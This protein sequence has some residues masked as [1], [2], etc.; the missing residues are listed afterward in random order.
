[1]AKQPIYP[2]VVKSGRSNGKSEPQII[3]KSYGI[4][5]GFLRGQQIFKLSELEP[6]LRSYFN[7]GAKTIVITYDALRVEWVLEPE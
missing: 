5:D 3:R 7:I 6:T 4:P 1:M 2:H